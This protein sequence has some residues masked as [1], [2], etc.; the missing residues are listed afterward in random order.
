MAPGKTDDRRHPVPPERRLKMSMKIVIILPTYNEKDN[1]RLLIPA[2]WQQFAGL[3][4]EMHV[5][6]VD[7]HSPDGTA[8]AVR[9]LMGRYANLHLLTGEKQGLG[10]AY[11]RGM[12]YALNELRAEAVMEMD[13]DFSHKPED[14]PRLLA[15]LDT[16]ADFVIG[17]RYIPGGSIPENWGRLRQAISRWGNIL[18]RYL[19]GLYRV[20]DCTAGFRAIRSSLLRKIDFGSLGVQGYAF[21]I[22]LLNQAIIQGA[23]M[24][25]IPVD[26]IDRQR[27]VTK[28]GLAD[29]IEFVINVWWIRFQASRTF[30]RFAAVGLLGVVVNLGLFILLVRFGLSKYLASPLSIEGSIISNFLLNNFWTFRHRQARGSFW[31]K[32]A[33]FKGVSLVALGVSYSA[34]VILNVL[35]PRTPAYI[36][37]FLAIFPATLVN[38]FLNSYWTFKAR[39]PGC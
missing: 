28:L 30:L 3:Q 13:A 12:T 17:S 38:Y 15:A 18:A 8:D 10:N 39:K 6:V 37:Q 35:S 36:H 7:D 22:A 29:I 1:I 21:Q 9:E 24:Q 32:A 14:V 4:H 34:F 20:K 27:G 16:G 33:K 26:F 2:L 23:A 25:E 31:T 11:I 19:A 5:L